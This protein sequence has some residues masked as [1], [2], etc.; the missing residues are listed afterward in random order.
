MLPIWKALISECDPLTLYGSQYTFQFMV[1]RCHNLLYIRTLGHAH[2]FY[3]HL[4]S[5][6]K[7]NNRT[8]SAVAMGERACDC[9]VSS[10]A[11]PGADKG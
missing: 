7:D 6:S 8:V 1:Q 2:S 11:H 9:L 10:S 5:A 3:S 4:D